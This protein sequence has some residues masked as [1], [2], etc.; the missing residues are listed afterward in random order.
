QS[1]PRPKRHSAEEPGSGLAG[2][3]AL[4]HAPQVVPKP[5]VL[6]ELVV[7]LL[8]GQLALVV[9]AKLARLPALVEAPPGAA[10]AVGELAIA[11]VCPAALDDLVLE[12]GIGAHRVVEDLDGAVVDA[13]PQLHTLDPVVSLD[14]G[15]R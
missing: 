3:R 15:H 13:L 9:V 14:H 1:N 7:A 12:L 4:R 8:R 6:D 2:S 10:G 5:R 11:S